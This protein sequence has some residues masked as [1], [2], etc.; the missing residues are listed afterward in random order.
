MDS[1]QEYI[2]TIALQRNQALDAAALN[3]AHLNVAQAELTRLAL[4]VQEL[5]AK[6]EPQ[7]VPAT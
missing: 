5:E 6:Y 3:L 1:T 2:N 7:A 4:R